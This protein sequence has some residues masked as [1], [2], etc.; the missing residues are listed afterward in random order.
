MHYNFKKQFAPDVE[1]GKKR[2]TIRKEGKRRPPNVGEQ[3]QLYTGM[4]TKVCRLL[5][6]EICKAV[7]EIIIMP[8]KKLVSF[9][10]S[11]RKQFIVLDTDCPE[12]TLLAEKDG[13]KSLDEFFEFFEKEVDESGIFE[14]H[15]IE[16]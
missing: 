9:F 11:S 7:S 3:L 12:L 13:F 16:W 4:R 2:Q 5:S 10:S 1:S 14:G 15:L 8:R 6:R